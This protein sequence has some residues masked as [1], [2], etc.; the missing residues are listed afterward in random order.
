L[1]ER[2]TLDSL[3]YFTS[4]S[5]HADVCRSVFTAAHAEAKQKWERVSKVS[6][7]KQAVRF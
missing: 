6:V 2:V 5:C 3:V 4:F 1:F 7:L